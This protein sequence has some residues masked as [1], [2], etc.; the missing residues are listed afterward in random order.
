MSLEALS[1]Y[2]L[3]QTTGIAIALQVVNL[4]DKEN[5]DVNRL[6]LDSPRDDEDSMNLFSSDVDL[7]HSRSEPSEVTNSPPTP[8]HC[9]RSPLR[10]LHSS[11]PAS[12]FYH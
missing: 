4:D 5:Q 10:S 7:S 2:L 1:M 6:F 11:R 9:D 12:Y 3:V 8:K